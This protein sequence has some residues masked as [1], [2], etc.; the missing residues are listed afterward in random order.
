VTEDRVDLKNEM[1]S[2]GQ[3]YDVMLAFLTD[4]W[5]RDFKNDTELAVLLGGMSRPQGS[6]EVPLDQATRQ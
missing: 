6:R 2:V 5:R 3:A 1:L 4:Y